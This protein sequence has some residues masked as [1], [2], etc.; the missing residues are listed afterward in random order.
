MVQSPMK[1]TL[2][3]ELRGERYKR[4]IVWRYR[5]MNHQFDPNPPS[6]A[7]WPWPESTTQTTDGGFFRTVVDSLKKTSTKNE[8]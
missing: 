4:G 7:Q 5:E 2:K 6:L 1:Q 3:Q 8:S